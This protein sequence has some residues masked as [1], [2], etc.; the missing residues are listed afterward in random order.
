MSES[1]QRLLTPEQL[2]RVVALSQAGVPLP[3]LAT[4]LA[5]S[6]EVIARSFRTTVAAGLPKFPR[7]RL[8]LVPDDVIPLEALAGA[9]GD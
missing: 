9:R 1:A 5:V 7:A 4:L 8:R 6:P 3:A 2:R